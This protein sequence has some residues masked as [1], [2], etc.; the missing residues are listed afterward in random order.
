MPFSCGA[1]LALLPVAAGKVTEGEVGW[2]A[3]AGGSPKMNV[4]ADAATMLSPVTKANVTTKVT[5]FKQ[6]KNF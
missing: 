4:G 5:L 3:A 1:V 2:L 6:H